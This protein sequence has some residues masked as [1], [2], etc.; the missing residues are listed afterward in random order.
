M[1]PHEQSNLGDQKII[2]WVLSM[3]IKVVDAV[4]RAIK[5]AQAT[6]LITGEPTFLF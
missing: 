3:T 6:Q 5:M 2:G 4:I 1:A